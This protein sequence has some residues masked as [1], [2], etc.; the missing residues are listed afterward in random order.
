MLLMFVLLYFNRQ[1]VQSNVKPLIDNF[2]RSMQYKTIEK[3]ANEN[4]NGNI[5]VTHSSGNHDKTGGGGS[6]ILSAGPTTF[7]ATKYTS[8]ANPNALPPEVNV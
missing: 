6:G 4:M 5:S 1:R 2:Q 3:S 7:T 8:V